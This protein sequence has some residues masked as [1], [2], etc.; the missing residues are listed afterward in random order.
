MSISRDD[1]LSSAENILKNSNGE[2]C[3]RNSVSRAYYSIFHSIASI[4]QQPPSIDENGNRLN[5]GVH[6]RLIRYLEGNA[7]IDLS[8]DKKLLHKLANSM[9]WAKSAREDAD[10]HL[11]CNISKMKAGQVIEEAKRVNR[12]VSIL[13]NDQK[14]NK[15]TGS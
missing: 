13:Q 3:T 6:A 1:F 5:L 9:K 2:I 10:Y 4:V 11:N 8:L 14:E 12:W 15:K 7:H